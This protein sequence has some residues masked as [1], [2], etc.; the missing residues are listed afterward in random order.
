MKEAAKTFLKCHLGSHAEEMETGVAS[1]LV[2]LIAQATFP[3][4]VQ[5]PGG[6]DGSAGNDDCLRG[7]RDSLRMIGI[8]DVE[9]EDAVG[10]F[11]L[12]VE[13]DLVSAGGTQHSDFAPGLLPHVAQFLNDGRVRAGF[14]LARDEGLARHFSRATPAEVFAAETAHVARLPDAFR[15]ELVGS[16]FPK[17]GAF[18]LGW[19]GLRSLRQDFPR[20]VGGGAGRYDTHGQRR[21]GQAEF[22][23]IH[24]L[25][26]V[27]TD[28]VYRV[29]RTRVRFAHRGAVEKS[30]HLRI[31]GEFLEP[32]TGGDAGIQLG[33]VAGN[34]QQRLRHAVERLH[35]FVANGP[36]DQ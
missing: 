28:G 7:L 2:V 11:G 35:L 10:P 24:R 25:L 26:H 17:I 19:T 4:H 30:A 15:P 9:V 21:R 13:R 5:E 34:S 1:E 6:L 36:V 20:A 31:A 16:L 23:A 14:R 29:R 18:K 32:G 33:A 27:V 22:R 12:R 3:G 8:G